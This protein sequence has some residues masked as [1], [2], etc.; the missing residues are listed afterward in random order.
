MDQTNIPDFGEI[1]LKE[2]DSCL[3]KKHKQ[4]T[5][6]N[7]AEIYWKF[8]ATL[9]IFKGNSE[10]FTGLSELIIFRYLFHQLGSSAFIRDSVSDQQ[11]H[12]ISKNRRLGCNIPLVVNSKKYKP[13]IVVFQSDKLIAVISVKTYF[14]SGSNTVKGEI[15][16]L[17]KVK[18]SHPEIRAIAY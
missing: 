14:T 1:F 10:G 2:I 7:I 6:A 12:F 15:E 4:L 9:K 13:D 17:E 11:F 8:F 18:A 5:C 16:K 3:I